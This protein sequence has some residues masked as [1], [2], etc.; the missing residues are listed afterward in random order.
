MPTARSAKQIESM[1]FREGPRIGDFQG[2]G[3]KGGADDSVDVGVVEGPA[4]EFGS[5]A[6]RSDDDVAPTVVRACPGDSKGV[7]LAGGI[8]SREEGLRGWSFGPV[9]RGAV[10]GYGGR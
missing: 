3:E 9:Q 1:C 4:D 6:I 8:G 10:L 5:V 2:G 7:G